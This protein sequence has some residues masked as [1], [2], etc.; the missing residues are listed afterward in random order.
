MTRKSLNV[1]G[2][3]G[4]FPTSSLPGSIDHM[5]EAFKALDLY[6]KSTQEQ[7]AQLTGQERRILSL[8]A[9]GHSNPDIAAQLSLSRATVQNH[10]ANLRNKLDIKSDVDYVRIAVAHQLIT[11]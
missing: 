4:E 1:D 9:V 10:R 7:F 2:Y 6:A 11:L 5:I 8:I 3:S